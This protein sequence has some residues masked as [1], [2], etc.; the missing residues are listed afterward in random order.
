MADANTRTVRLALCVMIVT[1]LFFSTNLVFGRGVIGEVAPFTLAFLR[2]FCVCVALSPFIY[3]D[4]VALA[5]AFRAR[6]GLVLLL[7]TLGMWICGGWV[8]LGLQSTSATNGTLIF[9]TSPVI[10]ML[11]E[12]AFGGRRM[13]WREALGAAIAFLGVATIILRGEPA[14]LFALSFNAG[15][16]IIMT[17]AIAW[18]VYSILFRAPELGKPSNAAVL[19]MLAGV[20]ALLLLPVAF[21]E[22]ASGS[23]MPATSDAWTG[24]AGIVI[25]ASLLAF[26]GYQYGVRQLGPTL[27]SI[28]MYLMPAYG[29]ML[30]VLLLGER[31]QPFHL[32][33]IALVMSGV[34]LA[35]FP[36]GWLRRKQRPRS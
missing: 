16:L 27:T 32:G 7:A 21:Y 3:M 11:L 1:P 18:S 15:D 8:Y 30:A 20:G 22:W 17:G 4:R 24:I 29:V 5:E 31:L 12:A 25:C 2:W 9:T 34:I 14:A 13:G 35:T 23:R 26:S 33:G 6:P 28:F 10:V 19:G 36:A